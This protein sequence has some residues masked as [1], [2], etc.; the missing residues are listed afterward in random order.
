MKLNS[1]IRSSIVLNV[2]SSVFIDRIIEQ[3]Y[4]WRNT[5]FTEYRKAHNRALDTKIK[6]LPVGLRPEK[7]VYLSLGRV[8]EEYIVIHPNL[9]G[10]CI[11]GA[12]NIRWDDQISKSE[13][14]DS[15]KRAFKKKYDKKLKTPESFYSDLF[16]GNTDA[17]KI[18]SAARK[19]YRRS[20]E[21]I[22]KEME[23]VIRET[24]SMVNASTTL[25]T[26]LK[27]W[28]EVEQYLPDYIVNPNSANLPV[29]LAT[30]LNALIE[31]SKKAA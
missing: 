8:N 4:L 21:L 24:R 6:H 16:K 23:K 5:V 18:I 14:G 22:G 2:I 12:L 27:S 30:N 17:L 13:F 19:D 25:N 11:R 9:D 29:P 31:Q 1:K 26:L 10:S 15:L 7:G 20:M 28:P 3:E